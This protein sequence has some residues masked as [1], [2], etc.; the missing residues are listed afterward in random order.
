MISTFIKMECVY[1]FSVYVKTAQ[2]ILKI[3]IPNIKSC[4]YFG[5]WKLDIHSLKKFKS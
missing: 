5:S 4:A 3:F 1:V 2:P